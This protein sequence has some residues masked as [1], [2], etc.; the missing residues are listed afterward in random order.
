[1]LHVPASVR[2]SVL[3]FSSVRAAS[4]PICIC[5]PEQCPIK[6]RT[7]GTSK[8]VRYL[9]LCVTLSGSALSQVRTIFT[10]G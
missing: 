4:N 3:S 10:Q 7:P 2:F 9:A 8:F 1:M 5:F 6:P